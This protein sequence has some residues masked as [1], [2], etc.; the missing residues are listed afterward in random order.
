MLCIFVVSKC[1]TQKKWRNIFVLRPGNDAIKDILRLLIIS[2]I[3]SIM[4]HNCDWT[5]IQVLNWSNSPSLWLVYSFYNKISFIGLF[6]EVEVDVAQQ[7][8]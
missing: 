3:Y 8:N 4:L 2:L 6:P 5:V 1:R 7:L